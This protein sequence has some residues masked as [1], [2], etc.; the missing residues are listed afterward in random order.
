MKGFLKGNDPSLAVYRISQQPLL[1]SAFGLQE[2]GQHRWLDI[3]VFNYTDS[4]K[5]QQPG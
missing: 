1:V 4:V 2:F 3:A 5:Q